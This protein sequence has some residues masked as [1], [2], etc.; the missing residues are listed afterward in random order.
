[1][2]SI[3]DILFYCKILQVNI[4]RYWL[5]RGPSIHDQIGKAIVPQNQAISWYLV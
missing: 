3:L 4:L 2:F 1:M 5:Q